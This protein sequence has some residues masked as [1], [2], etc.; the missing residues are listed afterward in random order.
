MASSALRKLFRPATIVARHLWLGVSTTALALGWTLSNLRQGTLIMIQALSRS[1][2]MAMRTVWTA[3]TVVA[4]VSRQG[5]WAIKRRK[6]VSEVS[7]F[8]LTHERLLSL[9]V[10][11]VFL[12]L[13]V[14]IPVRLLWPSPPEPTVEVV[15][16]S[17]GHLTRDGLLPEMAKQF[18][19][20]GH[21]IGSGT[22]IVVE[23][24]NVP[25]E[26]RGK[27]LSELLRFG[28]RRDLNKETNGYVVKNIPDPTIVTPSSAHWLVTLNYEVGR[29]VVDIESA[30][31]IVRPVIGI[32]TYRE[33]ANC[34]GWPEK[35]IGFADIIALRNDPQGWAS[36]PC[37][38]GEWGQ[39]PLLAFT[40]PTTSSTGR[41]LHL[42][43]YSIA[44]GKSPQDLTVDD[45]KDPK[46]VAYVKEFQGLIDHYLIGTTVLNTKIYQGPRYGHFF[47]MPEDNLIHLYEGTEK[48]YLNGIKATAP[49]IE[50]NSMV[51]IYPK[52]GSMPRNNCAC[53]VDA[54][55]VSQEQVEASQQWVDFIR[56]DEQQRAFMAAGFRPGTD[57]DLSY[58]GS[59]INS[60]FGLNPDEPKV[61]L[62]PSLTR[63]EVAAAIDDSREQ[64]KRPGIVTFVV[65]TSGSMFGGKIKQAKD[66][67]V[68]ALGAMASNNQ[69]GL[70]TFDYTINTTIPVGPLAE[71]RFAI[72]DAVQAMRAIGETALYE[73]IKAGIEMT[74]A[75]PGDKNPI[76]GV[77]VL[78]DGQAN[79]C[80]TRLD[81]LIEMTSSYEHPITEF[82]G[83]EAEQW[84]IDAD[85]RRV[86][87]RQIIGA[88]LAIE[89]QH[90]IQIFYIGI[91]GDADM[92][93]GRM[94]A[95]ATGAEFQG[96]DEKDLANVLEE[97]S[98]YF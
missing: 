85:G 59:K 81:D 7:D 13:V 94:L 10:T 21:T 69:V 84:A 27:Y 54:D 1:P 48:S 61:V 45:V 44:A 83:C 89:T 37:A 50:K 58:V 52:E 28:T 23:V 26:L 73:A 39:R 95:E 71:N 78:T 20:E 72:G 12:F 46:V 38:K 8:N 49:P 67:L 18:N 32:V 86:D 33:M 80:K 9:V 41:S 29:P 77:V 3:V 62:N 5:M 51:M 68:L 60:Q 93:I 14:A 97:F 96:V 70:V 19:D 55:W 90:T 35:E 6:G 42:A 75:A 79:R 65:D 91:G 76:R 17:T 2:G 15:H 98:K 53:I 57:L 87:K 56:R 47:I 43:L 92:D 31:S 34:L 82:R 88:K 36:Y 25:S 63:P 30:E 66:G 11:G 74:D 40:D 64:V 24:Y 4:D 22:R 16:W